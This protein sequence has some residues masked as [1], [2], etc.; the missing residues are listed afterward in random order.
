MNHPTGAA[1]G[2]PPLPSPERLQ[3]LFFDAA[4]MGR[5]DVIP[6][7][8]Q[9]GVDIG[10]RDPRGYTALIL[11]SYN[12]QATTTDLLLAAGAEVDAADAARGNTALHGVAFKGHAGIAQA[13]IDAGAAVDLPNLAGQTALMMAALFDQVAI[14]DMLLGAGADRAAT[15]AAGNSASSVAQAQGNAAMAARVSGASRPG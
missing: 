3:Q 10:A 11:A 14:V 12:G 8:L 2:M 6:A 15:D 4:R 9:A 5:D 13:L 1:A 7:L